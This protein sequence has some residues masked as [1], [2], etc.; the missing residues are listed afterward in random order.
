MQNQFQLVDLKHISISPTN[1]MFR[2]SEEMQNGSIQELVDSVKSKGII[3]PILLRPL[4]ANGAN[5]YELVA[6]ERRYRAAT[7]VGLQVIPA[8]IKELT[9]EEALDL[10]LTENLQRKDV[11]P[12]KEARAFKYLQEKDPKKN[13]PEELAVRF[14]KSVTYVLQR[15]KLNDLI[16]EIVKDYESGMMTLSHA[17]IICRLTPEDQK[18]VREECLT[19]SYHNGK[20]TAK[21]YEHASELEDFIE[22]SITCLLSKASF[23]LDDAELNKKAGPCT[24]CS[25][26]SGANQLF[27]DVKEKD[28]CFDSACYEI[29]VSVHLQKVVRENILNKP[30]LAYFKT[31]HDKVNPGVEKMLKEE[32]IK[33]LKQHD[34]FSERKNGNAASIRGMWINGADAG[35]IVTV[36][37]KVEKTT[38]KGNG[39][40]AE[41]QDTEELV[42]KIKER[43]ERAAEL[44]QE[45]VYARILNEFDL[46]KN[47]AFKKN[48]NLKPTELDQLMFSFIVWDQAGRHMLEDDFQ[49]LFK[50]PDYGYGGDSK[51]TT[52]FIAALQA[53]SVADKILML[54]M[55]MRQKYAGQA[56]A[57]HGI[58]GQ[59]IKQM[60]KQ[61]GGIPV[62]QFEKEQSEE[63]IKRETRAK[64]RIKALQAEG[65]PK[66][67]KK[68]KA[69]KKA[70]PKAKVEA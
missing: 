42:L 18:K 53:M 58:E 52:K 51:E 25:K 63:R 35:K 39:K 61:F 29:K 68:P 56:T 14:G 5:K 64:E 37:S 23:K 38:S 11:H 49:K 33:V 66:A 20:K 16:P 24:T 36:Y 62:D 50:L 45:K 46:E 48:P 4:P 2:D 21:Y 67:E 70:K 59:L 65:K 28:R 3:Q 22:R 19:E 26:R 13:T 7:A 47:Q 31:Y 41:K 40:A 32:K 55:T 6:G 34:D 12:I 8:L 44:D 30:D 60:A 1:H 43:V 10:Q 9:D 57:I 54:R 17:L 69:K 27:N 15:L